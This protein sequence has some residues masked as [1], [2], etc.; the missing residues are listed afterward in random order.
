MNDLWSKRVTNRT[1]LSLVVALTVERLAIHLLGMIDQ[2][3]LFTLSWPICPW[4]A[5]M[6]WFREQL[7]PLPQRA[8][9][10]SI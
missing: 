4:Q 10:D 1:S 2:I 3:Q 7:I 9:L 5:I 6:P 8:K